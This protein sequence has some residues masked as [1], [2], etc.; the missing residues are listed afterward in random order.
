MSKYWFFGLI[1]LFYTCKNS[2][3][4]AQID[5][6]SIA[7]I[8]KMRVANTLDKPLMIDVYTDWCKWCKVMDKQT[9]PDPAVIAY[10]NEHFYAV[11][12]DAEQKE[13]VVLGG[14]SFAY[15]SNGRSGTNMLAYSLLQGELSFPSI[16]YMSKDLKILRIAP[17]YKTPEQLMGE[18]QD[19]SR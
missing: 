3:E 7:D 16:V 10:I 8:E 5:W 11:K 2:S 9:F 13:P 19:I 6:K 12:F 14:Q 15:Q 1:V 17:G 4:S 18:M